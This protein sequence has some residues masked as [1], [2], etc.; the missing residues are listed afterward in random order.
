MVANSAIAQDSSSLLDAV[1]EIDKIEAKKKKTFSQSVRENLE[2]KGG[3][4]GIKEVPINTLYFVEAERGTYLV[5]SDGRF[6]IDG[7]IKDVWHRKSITSLADMEDIDR[8]PLQNNAKK[9]EEALATFTIGDS[10]LP[11]SGV[12]FVDPSSE[13]TTQA[14]QTLH[15]LRK[16]QKWTVVLMPLVG[17]KNAVERSR[18]LFCSKDQAVALNDLIN[19]TQDSYSSQ[20]DECDEQKILAAKYVNHV[21]GIE[22]LPHLIREDGLVSKGFPV[23]FDEWYSQP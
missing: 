5:T 20:K 14:L 9:I 13:Y 12:I 15:D 22:N 4:I 8:V 3:I 23:E 1:Q 2:K 18:Y 17:G 6:V 19:G 21:F 7:V 11:R 16:E 10:S